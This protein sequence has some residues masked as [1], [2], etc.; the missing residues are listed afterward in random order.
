MGV[1]YNGLTQA[2]YKVVKMQNESSCLWV[3]ISQLVESCKT[4]AWL[5]ADILMSSWPVWF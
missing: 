4:H 2:K 5:Q 1:G 3:V